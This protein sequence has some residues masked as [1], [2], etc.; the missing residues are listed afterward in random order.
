MHECALWN[1]PMKK[2]KQRCFILREYNTDSAYC[3]QSFLLLFQ[4]EMG[5]SPVFRHLYIISIS[6]S[7]IDMIK[8]YCKS[9]KR[10]NQIKI[11]E[12]SFIQINIF[13]QSIILITKLFVQMYSCFICTHYPEIK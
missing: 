6:I 4:S 5:E 8:K 11:T 12:L 2:L 9:E 3:K 7:P 10:S 13:T 1:I